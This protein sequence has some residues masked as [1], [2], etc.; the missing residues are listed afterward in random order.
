MSC[1]TGALIGFL[2]GFLIG[3]LLGHVIEAL[4]TLLKSSSLLSE[5]M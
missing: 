4:Q 5:W 1:L 3:L 2:I